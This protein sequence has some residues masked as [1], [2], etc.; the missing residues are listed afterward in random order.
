MS[1]L[2]EADNRL[3]ES[4][5]REVEQLAARN[6]RSMTDTASAPPRSVVFVEQ[7]AHG[8]TKGMGVTCW[9]GVWYPF[10]SGGNALWG[11]VSKTVGADRFAVVIAGEAVVPGL[12]APAGSLFACTAGVWSAYSPGSYP[13]RPPAFMIAYGA[14]GSSLVVANGA[15][16]Q[17]LTAHTGFYEQASA[18]AGSVPG[19]ILAL[20]VDSGG[21][22]QLTF[23][24]TGS[25]ERQRHVVG[26]LMYDLGSSVWLVL[27][28]GSGTAEYA[29]GSSLSDSP[30][31]GDIDAVGR[32]WISTTT[33]GKL[34]GI[35][36]VGPLHAVFV[37][38]GGKSYTPPSG[39]PETPGDYTT[40]SMCLSGMGAAE[41]H[42]YPIPIEGGGTGTDLN[43]ITENSILAVKTVSGS[44]KVFGYLN[45]GNLG[46]LS[47]NSSGVPVWINPDNGTNSSMEVSGTTLYARVCGKRSNAVAPTDKQFLRYNGTTWEAYGPLLALKGHL[48]SHDG[49]DFQDVDASTPYSVLGVASSPAAVPAAIEA[50]NDQSV[51]VRKGTVQF[52][53]A[54]AA[55][56]MLQRGSSGLEFSNDPTLTRSAVDYKLCNVNTITT[57]TTAPSGA[58]VK[59]QMHF[60]Y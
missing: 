45:A 36:P 23:A 29:G 33:A 14:G 34:T 46:F 42:P 39:I 7:A 60:I 17:G 28:G 13:A 9:D 38:V 11:I 18:P 52:L 59:G 47:Q 32:C 15:S 31:A 51:L 6:P 57:S 58:G 16:F 37:G 12:S 43:D 40:I 48:L 19:D 20:P 22:V 50:A 27:V 54:A 8:F 2:S 41:A 5:Q 10:S 30:A 53:A 35:K 49:T 56:S 24:G 1:S 21:P 25:T 55:G 3:T 4:L 26:V 44:K